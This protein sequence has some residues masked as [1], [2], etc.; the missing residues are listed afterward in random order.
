MNN[1]ALARFAPL[2]GLLFAGL[3]VTVRI[4]EG[5]CGARPG[6]WRV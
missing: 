1:K 5:P 3:L 6:C 2:T 4:I